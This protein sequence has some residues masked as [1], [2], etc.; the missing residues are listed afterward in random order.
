MHKH[1]SVTERTKHFYARPKEAIV[2]RKGRS[3]FTL[4]NIKMRTV[5]QEAKHGVVGEIR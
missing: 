4:W 2:W 1:G 5:S 3:A